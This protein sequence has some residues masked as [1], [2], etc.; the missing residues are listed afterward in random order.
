MDSLTLSV[1]P[2]VGFC[3]CSMFCCALVFVNSTFAISLMRKRELLGVLLSLSSWSLVIVV[4][5][6][7]VCS[8]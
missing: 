5:H 1:T 4:C 2:I 3:K 6:G 7:F 8:L